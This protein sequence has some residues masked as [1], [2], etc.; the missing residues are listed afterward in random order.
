MFYEYIYRPTLCVCLC[1]CV[2]VV[3]NLLKQ[4]FDDALKGEEAVFVCLT[5]GGGFVHE[6]L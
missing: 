6:T 1:V 4:T 2:C 3:N 5:S